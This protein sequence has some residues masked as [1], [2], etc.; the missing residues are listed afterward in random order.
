MIDIGVPLYMEPFWPAHVTD[1]TGRGCIFLMPLFKHMFIN[2]YPLAKIGV[3]A[4]SQHSNNQVN[5]RSVG[6]HVQGLFLFK[7]SL[8][9]PID[10]RQRRMGLAPRYLSFGISNTKMIV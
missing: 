5:T 2:I 10:W 3:L 8:N 1:R 7:H 6:T 9:I 4:S